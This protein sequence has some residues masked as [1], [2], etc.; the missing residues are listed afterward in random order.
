MNL[1][2]LLDDRVA[3]ALA[4][5]GTDAD[6]LVRTA[7][8]PE[9]GDYQA[10]GIMAAAKR[11]GQQ[12]RELAAAVIEALLDAEAQADQRLIASAEVAGPGFINLRLD[13][14]LL[15]APLL[16]AEPLISRTNRPQKVVVDYSSPNLAKEMHVGHLR[17]TIIGDALARMFEALGHQVIRQNHVGD[18]GTQFGML[19]TELGD[20][21]AADAGQTFALTDLQSFYQ[22]AKRRFDADPDFAERSRQAV[23]ELQ[24]GAP[25]TRALWQQFVD[26]SLDHAQELYDRLGVSLTRADVMA[27]SA[28]NDALPGIVDALKQQGLVTTSEGAQCVFLDDFTNKKGEPLPIIVQK[29]DGGYL[30][31]TT[32]LAAVQHRQS[33]A[34]DRVLYLVDVRQSLHFRQIFALAR[35]AGLAQPSMS[36]EHLA[37]GT[38]LGTDGKPFK[39]REGGVVRLEDVLDEAEKRA[40]DLLSARA[41]SSAGSTVD[42][43]QA[44]AHAIAIG[45]VKYSDLSKNRT[46]DYVFDWDQML[47]FDG[48]TAPYLQYAYSRVQSLLSR[49]AAAEADFQAIIK[50]SGDSSCDRELAPQER[51]L[52]LALLRF[53]ETVE[54]TT[55]EGYPHYLCGYLYE[56]ATRYSQ[57]YEAI[58]VMKSAEPERA[59]RL[60]LCWRTGE[61]LKTGL[62]LLGIAVVDRM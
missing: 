41:A 9:F 60:R 8:R 35:A 28:Y 50:D 22:Q 25:A 16:R 18:W 39:T 49:A 42:D 37:F 34:V 47:S 6:A 62:A 40:R 26:L 52:A 14:A 20:Q 4:T 46:S 11:S 33:L 23:V 36:L 29:Q 61:T 19:I 2:A 48:D 7:A 43:Q 10:N 44:V 30:Y 12:P 15:S 59:Q 17:S 53:Q 3:A 57:F 55:A 51:G 5:V 21:Q 54:Q 31:A 32:D 58:P 24:Q 38:M 56:L 45:A 13:P 27:E 1:R